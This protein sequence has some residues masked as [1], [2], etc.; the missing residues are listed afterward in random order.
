MI[1]ATL[2]N[3]QK[4]KGGELGDSMPGDF[5]LKFG[6]EEKEPPTLEELETKLIVWAQAVNSNFD[7]SQA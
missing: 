6:E 4:N 7:R 1:C 5:L 2:V 3:I